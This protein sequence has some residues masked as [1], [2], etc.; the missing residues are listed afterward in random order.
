[1]FQL[2]SSEDQD[3][4]DSDAVSITATGNFNQRDY[5]RLGGSHDKTEINDTT[6]M[7]G[8]FVYYL[9]REIAIT[10]NFVNNFSNQQREVSLGVIYEF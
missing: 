7:Y 9:N 6:S 5:W 1:M 10:G 3:F 2:F 8:E 4:E